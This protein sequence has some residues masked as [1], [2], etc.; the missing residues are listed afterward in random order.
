MADFNLDVAFSSHE[1]PNDPNKPIAMAYGFTD[2]ADQPNTFKGKGQRSLTVPANSQVSFAIYDT[3][4]NP[5]YDVTSVQISVVNKGGAGQPKSP[6]SNSVWANGSITAVKNNPG[7]GQLQLPPSTPYPGAFST[8]CNIKN[9]TS[10]DIGSFTVATL[11]GR[12][13][14]DITIHVVTQNG[15]QSQKSFKVDPEVVVEGGNPDEG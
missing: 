4:Q 12:Q 5:T 1:T 11:Q 8:G 7:P 3:A 14:F 15:Q 9:A 6:F 13:A 2:D 10:W